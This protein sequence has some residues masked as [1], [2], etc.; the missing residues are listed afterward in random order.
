VWARAL[1]A[2]LLL[3]VGALPAW[4][5]EDPPGRVGRLNYVQGEVSFSPAGSDEWVEAGTSRPITSGDRLWMGRDARSELSI[6]SAVVHSDGETSLKVLQLDDDQAQFQL[7]EGTVAVHVRNMDP[8]DR[9]EIATPNQ[10][11]VIERPGDYRVQVDPD[12]NV[13]TITVEHGRGTAYADDGRHRLEAPA[14]ARFVAEGLDNVSGDLPRRDSF[15][16]WVD[17]RIERAESRQANRYLSRDLV[18]YED[19]DDYGSWSQEP[20]YGPVW[21]PRITVATWAPYRYGHWAWIA[22]W[23]WTWVDDAPWGFA[24]FHYGRWAHVRNRWCWVPGPVV[25]RPYYAPALV[26]FVGSPG[27]SFTISSGPAVA[28]FPLGPREEYRPVYRASTTYVTRINHVV[29]V[30]GGRGGYRPPP[31]QYV[32]RFIPGAATALPARAFVEGRPV[33]REHIR[34]SERELQQAPVAATMPT[35]APVKTSLV[36]Q[37]SRRRDPPPRQANERQVVTTRM[38]KPPPVE[39]DELAKRFAQ[40][41]GLVREAGPTLVE[42]PPRRVESREDKTPRVVVPRAPGQAN[43]ERRPPSA[44]QQ[45]VERRGQQ[46]QPVIPRPQ[47]QERALRGP[48]IPGQE[49]AP[50]PETAEQPQ[51][52][53]QPERREANR[54]P[55]VPRAAPEPRR[56]REQGPRGFGL[57]QEA[58]R[59][60]EAPEQ[61]QLRPQF[62]RREANRPQ[63]AP[64]AAPPESRREREQGPR[65]FG[66]NQESPREPGAGAAPRQR[67]DRPDE[68]QRQRERPEAQRPVEAR[69]APE[70]RRER[71]PEPQ[72]QERPSPVFQRPEG[73]RPQEVQQAA[74][75]AREIQP[76]QQ[77]EPRAQPQQAQERRQDGGREQKDQKEQQQRE[78]A[79]KNLGRFGIQQE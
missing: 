3:V 63:E 64:R 42:Q 7:S 45:Q 16:R 23:G 62:E 38:P 46:P 77:R 65:G 20:D 17:S 73:R 19:L 11:F 14:Y 66:L 26:A 30:E 4:A 34:V 9:L 32:N 29:V 56:E 51:P 27:A 68:F 52:R 28:W 1:A 36:G 18:G 72:V 31:G 25:R 49:E 37:D 53:P 69:P 15:D 35:L 60:P 10:A 58:P 12:N 70:P 44:D 33:G 76:M 71:P 6:G 41:G 48:R 13:T 5:Q 50:R 47:E 57:N 79:E 8:D 2:L 61:P 21:V 67:P 24:P 39:R 78:R 54:P 40:S 43:E 55:E 22:P 59:P 75:Q 74:P